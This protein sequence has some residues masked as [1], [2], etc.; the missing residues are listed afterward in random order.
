MQ[1]FCVFFG[2]VKFCHKILIMIMYMTNFVVKILVYLILPR[3]SDVFEI[4]QPVFPSQFVYIYLNHIKIEM[5]LKRLK[6]KKL[7]YFSPC[8]SCSFCLCSHSPL[9]LLWKP[10]ILDLNPVHMNSPWVRGHLEVVMHLVTY[11]LP[12]R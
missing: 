6:R 10:H 7:N 2:Q 12:V 4:P 11:G 9:H 8:I 3:Q 5:R 1:I